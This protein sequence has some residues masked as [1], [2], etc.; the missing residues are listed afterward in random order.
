M[1]F[2]SKEDEEILSVYHPLAIYPTYLDERMAAQ[3]AC[4][5]IFGNKINGLLSFPDSKRKFID[6]VDIPKENKY[7]ILNELRLLGIDYTSVYPDLDG[8]GTSINQTFKKEFLKNAE[9]L[10]HMFNCIQEMISKDED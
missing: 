6:F 9:A 8:L 4:F 5:T 7:S 3:K 2:E 1:D 10:P